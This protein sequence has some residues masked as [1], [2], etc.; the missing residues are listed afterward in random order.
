MNDSAFWG[1]LYV[2]FGGYWEFTSKICQIWDADFRFPAIPDVFF[3]FFRLGFSLSKQV[4][5]AE[6]HTCSIATWVRCA[7]DTIP[8]KVMSDE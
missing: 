6:I 4:I 7:M 3:F 1:Q 8:S 2:N 5:L